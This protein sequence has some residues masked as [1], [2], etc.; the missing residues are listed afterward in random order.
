MGIENSTN[1]LIHQELDK[2]ETN[3]KRPEKTE[4]LYGLNQFDMLVKKISD[5]D[6]ND[7]DW[8]QISHK[9]LNLIA[10]HDNN[11]ATTRAT[12]YQVYSKAQILQ[13]LA[14][15]RQQIYGQAGSL[16]Q[17]TSNLPE[18]S[19]ANSPVQQKHYLSEEK[20]ESFKTKEL[21]SEKTISNQ[22][23]GSVEK[24]RSILSIP[25]AEL[26]Q[27]LEKIVDLV[28]PNV[29]TLR[30]P[31]GETRGVGFKMPNHSI[32]SANHVTKFYESST[33]SQGNKPNNREVLPRIKVE[34]GSDAVLHARNRQEAVKD[35]EAL[36]EIS[37]NKHP[38]AVIVS[39][40][41]PQDGDRP[42]VK[43]YPIPV[44]QAFHPKTGQ[45]LRYREGFGV[46][47]RGKKSNNDDATV[48][49]GNPN[50]NSLIQKVSG[51]P[52]FSLQNPNIPV[53]VA[54]NHAGPVG[55][56]DTLINESLWNLKKSD[57][58][59]TRATLGGIQFFT[60]AMIETAL[61]S[62]K[63]NWGENHVSIR[64]RPA[65]SRVPT[66]EKTQP[67][68][69]IPQP[70]KFISSRLDSI[71]NPN[72]KIVRPDNAAT[73]PRQQPSVNN[74]NTL[75]PR[76]YSLVDDPRY[77]NRRLNNPLNNN[78]RNNGYLDQK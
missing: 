49:F 31:D 38:N 17:Q 2:L 20:I 12:D 7:I 8:Q 21:S 63:P 5:T 61:R 77:R 9:I 54:T 66:V 42:L 3:I 32:L 70:Q 19:S 71:P 51:S 78:P 56:V 13:L 35:L 69:Q 62:I 55:G 29:F 60:P 33:T 76:K 34:I 46:P 28:A 37:K 39:N 36:L 50:Y 47:D 1:Q 64:N 4:T 23:R 75:R 44:T 24:Q 40:R 53:G 43:P 57:P 68:R 15:L 26:N 72:F 48:V 65:I 52:V 14:N 22:S 16:P 10:L 74:L 58:S 18:I 11:T 73:K 41:N 27:N 30:G 25:A 59:I 6:E 45:P 67:R